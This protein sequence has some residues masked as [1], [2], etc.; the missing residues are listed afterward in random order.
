MLVS[1]PRFEKYENVDR[2]AARTFRS[3]QC[4]YKRIYQMCRGA[5]RDFRRDERWSV[6]MNDS[7]IGPE[8]FLSH[9]AG[10]YKLAAKEISILEKSGFGRH[11]DGQDKTRHTAAFRFGDVAKRPVWTFSRSVK[12]KDHL[13]SWQS[14]KE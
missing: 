7:R 8:N 2:S 4:V 11:R 12:S 3:E 14:G 10:I 1:V 13:A 6:L 9:K 5:S